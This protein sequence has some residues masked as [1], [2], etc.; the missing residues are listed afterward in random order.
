[1]EQQPGEGWE[2]RQSI[3]Y[4]WPGTIPG[5]L[6]HSWKGEGPG[7]AL[8]EAE[9]VMY[10]VGCIKQA[11]LNMASV[12]YQVLRFWIPIMPSKVVRERATWWQ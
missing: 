4:K 11:P 9:C 10:Q 2:H 12:P 1:M 5:P 3:A 7:P 6:L 8:L